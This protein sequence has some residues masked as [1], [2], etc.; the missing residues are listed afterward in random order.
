[1]AQLDPDQLTGCPAAGDLIAYSPWRRYRI[2]E[3]RRVLNGKGTPTFG[4]P[5]WWIVTCRE[6]QDGV[7]IG[8]NHTR[9]YIAGATAFNVRPLSEV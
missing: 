1:M 2:L 9:I 6:R 5:A 8:R 7:L 3:V 4:A